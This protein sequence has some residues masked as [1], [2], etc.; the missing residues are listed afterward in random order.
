M[1]WLLLIMHMGSSHQAAL[2]TV[3]FDS[4]EHCERAGQLIVK[5]IRERS[6][7]FDHFTQFECIAIEGASS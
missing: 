7:L 5:R 3:V 1:R 6:S 2:D 4:Q